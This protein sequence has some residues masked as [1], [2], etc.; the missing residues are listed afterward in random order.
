MV[1]RSTQ[2]A[3]RRFVDTDTHHIP[4]SN[5]TIFFSFIFT[6]TKITKKFKG[7]SIRTYVSQNVQMNYAFFY[8]LLSCRSHSSV[9]IAA[10][11]TIF[12]YDRVFKL[13]CFFQSKFFIVAM[14]EW[15]KIKNFQYSNNVV[16]TADLFF[17]SNFTYSAYVRRLALNFGAHYMFPF[18]HRINYSICHKLCLP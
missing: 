2:Y 17:S 16:L 1:C 6:I 15:K 13:T 8:C 3:Q 4:L 11:S 18:L 9:A 14:H 7:F 12:V 10:F 5:C